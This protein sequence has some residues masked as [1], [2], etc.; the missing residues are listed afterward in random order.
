MGLVYG[1]KHFAALKW[2]GDDK[3][4]TAKINFLDVV[5]LQR[6]PLPTENLTEILYS[7]IKP[8]KIMAND[9]ANYRRMLF[10]KTLTADQCY[11]Y[12]MKMWDRHIAEQKEDKNDNDLL[13]AFNNL[14]NRKSANAAISGNT[15]NKKDIPCRYHGTEKGC[16]KGKA[17]PYS[18]SG[19]AGKKEKGKGK[20]RSASP[21][22]NKKEFPCFKNALGLCNKPAK[23]CSFSHRALKPDELPALEKFKKRVAE[24]K[25]K[26]KAKAGAA[27]TVD[28]ADSNP[29]RSKTPRKRS[30][31][32]KDGANDGPAPTDNATPKAKAPATAK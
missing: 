17:C 30:K 21:S 6:S 25:A 29:R 22:A 2:L 16:S 5:N 9:L 3:L 1:V 27:V 7:F 8:S 32:P 12:L 18:H 10:E 14:G 19:H 24:A 11:D 4:E 23:E 15:T 13:N 20:G 28:G 26:A 31:K